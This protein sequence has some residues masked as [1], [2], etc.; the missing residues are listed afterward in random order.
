[1]FEEIVTDRNMKKDIQDAYKSGAFNDVSIVCSDGEQVAT[2][3]SFLAM[4]VPF[5]EKMFFGCFRE[6]AQEKVEFKSCDSKT[7]TYILEYIWKGVL[8]LKPLTLY[9]L[10]GIMETSRL[11]CLNSLFNNV[12][13]ILK[14]R[15]DRGKADICECLDALDF[16]AANKHDTLLHCLFGYVERNLSKIIDTTRFESLSAVAVMALLMV[17]VKELTEDTKFEVFLNWKKKNVIDGVI[18]NEM[19]KSFDLKKFSYSYISQTVVKSGFFKHEDIIS[20]LLEIQKDSTKLIKQKDHQIN[21]L[22]GKI[23]KLEKNESKGRRFCITE[24]ESD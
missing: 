16:A 13:C 1:M 6:A 12:E 22:K 19:L 24:S 3:K 11:L 21:L 7:F 10:L 14:F 17:N 8:K 18:Q 15:I 23:D 2:N 5:F 4:R 20:A 9:T